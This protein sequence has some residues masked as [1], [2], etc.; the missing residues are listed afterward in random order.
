MEPL[1]ALSAASRQTAGILLITIVGVEWGGWAVLGMVRGRTPVTDFQRAFAR[2]GHAH[3]GVLVIFGLI[4]QVL[5]DATRL[6]GPLRLIARD[7]VPLAAIL[8]PLG[9]FLS[10]LRRGATAPNRLIVLL[11]LGIASLALGVLALGYGLFAA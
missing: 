2:A 4:C 10:S 1:L 7:G 6:D 11:Y 3:A 8:F 9:Y 5:A